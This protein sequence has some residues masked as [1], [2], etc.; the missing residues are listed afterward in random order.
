MDR[1]LLKGPAHSRPDQHSMAPLH[2][3][4]NWGL[5]R[6][7][8]CFSSWSEITCSA[9][10]AVPVSYS[11][12]ASSQYGFS[13]AGLIPCESC[14]CCWIFVFYLSFRVQGDVLSLGFV[15]EFAVG[16]L[17]SSPCYPFCFC[18]G[19]HAVIIPPS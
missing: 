8:P 4:L 1:S 18:V 7:P 5:Y 15:I 12:F 14:C 9:F 2:P 6:L 10:Y 13:P 17:F 16:L 19:F 11:G 3:C